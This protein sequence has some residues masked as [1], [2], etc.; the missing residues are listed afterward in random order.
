MSLTAVPRVRRP[1]AAA[2][3]GFSIKLVICIILLGHKLL[4]PAALISE[5]GALFARDKAARPRRLRLIRRQS[6]DRSV[7][8]RRSEVWSVDRMTSS[9][10]RQVDK[11]TVNP[12][13]LNYGNRDPQC[14]S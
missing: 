8:R 5:G 12:F 11:Q 1:T 9:S 2:R 7:R 13:L 4:K 10:R 14:R 3:R 6:V